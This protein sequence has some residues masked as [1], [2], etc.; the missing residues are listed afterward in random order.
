VAEPPNLTPLD[1]NEQP[2]W[3]PHW[4]DPRGPSVQSS[5][6]A[7]HVARVIA[8]VGEAICDRLESVVL[9]LRAIA[10]SNHPD[11]VPGQTP[12]AGEEGGPHG[13]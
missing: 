13:P 5:M 2:P 6:S 4:S 3:D 10:R 11:R 8:I 12:G 7:D 1:P 9:E